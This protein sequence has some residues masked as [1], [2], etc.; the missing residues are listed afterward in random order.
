MAMGDTNIAGNSNTALG[1][2]AL[3]RAYASTG[4]TGVGVFA[5]YNVRGDFNTAVGYGA[6]NSVGLGK[7]NVA[8]GASALAG[9]QDGDNNVAIGYNA[10]NQENFGSDNIGIGRDCRI[11]G[12]GADNSIVIGAD[13]RGLGS[14]TTVIGNNFTTL[15]ELRG[16][17]SLPEVRNLNF[18]D[19][20]AAA[21]GGV[22]IDAI[23]HNAGI[24][25][26]RLV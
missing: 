17:L 14:N 16:D 20:A 13:A 25:R 6:L 11:I 5:L 24:L 9:N 4:N 15:T 26:I 19:D 10:F 1:V 3:E 12:K 2:S 7:H 23:Y 21:L 8:V 22:P 18:I